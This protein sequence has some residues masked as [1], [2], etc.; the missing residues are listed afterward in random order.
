MRLSEITRSD[1]RSDGGL[2]EHGGEEGD[3]GHQQQRDDAGDDHGP[4]GLGHGLDGDLGLVLEILQLVADADGHEQVHA[5]GGS[6]LADGQVHSGDDAEMHQVDP[7]LLGHGVHDGDE[8]VHGGVGVHKAAGDQEDDVDDDQ[9]DVLVPGHRQQHR[10]GGLGDAVD[11]ADV[12][13]Q[14]GG[15]DDEHDAAGGLAGVHQKIVQILDLDLAVDEQAHD[16][17]VHHGDGRRLSGGE[18][19]AIDAAQD[20]DGHQKAPEG[21]AEGLPPLAPGGPLPGG[22]QA[23]APDLDHDDDHQGQAHH[24]AG[25]DAAHEHVAHGHAGDGGVDHE[26]DGGRN[27]DGDGRGR[28]HH[29]RGEGGG[30]AAAVDHGGNQDDAQGR[31]RG[32]TGAGDGAEEAGHHHADDG[33]AAPPVAD[34]VVNELDQTGGDAGLGHDVAGEHEERNGQQQELGHAVVHIG[35]HHGQLVA[36]EQHGEHGAHAQAHTDGDVQKQHHEEAAK[37]DQINHC[38]PPLPPSSRRR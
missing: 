27:D 6:H 33:D 13:K 10:L 23:L 30:E 35:G 38:R 19:A 16:Q 28:C 21:G 14:G 7:Q 34:A 1:G 5:H 26:G 3:V 29:G 32:G 9:E 2:Q 17:A 22:G 31:H 20:D 11:R 37:Q 4:H 36:G 24:D 15:A 12:G 18:D 25:E 8:D